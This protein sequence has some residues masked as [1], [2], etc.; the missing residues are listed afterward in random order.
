MEILPSL[1]LIPFGASSLP[2]DRL[3]QKSCPFHIQS[4]DRFCLRHCTVV[5][6]PIECVIRFPSRAPLQPWDQ[7]GR[8]RHSCRSILIG[9]A[10]LTGLLVVRSPPPELMFMP[11]REWPNVKNAVEM[12]NF[13]VRSRFGWF[14]GGFESYSLNGT[15]GGCPCPLFTPT[16]L[17][18]TKVKIRYFDD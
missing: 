7:A 14:V 6:R 4:A 13:Y 11:V 16:S 8:Q 3:S 1:A 15:R 17:H 9:K 12:F 5:S 10:A 2:P 18:H